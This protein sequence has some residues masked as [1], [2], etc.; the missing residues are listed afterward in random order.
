LFA[1]AVAGQEI[2]VDSIASIALS[3]LV[4]QQRALDV[5]A[6]N[7]ANANT[8]GYHASRM[9]F[10]DWLMKEPSA[11][12]PPGGSKIAYTHDRATYRDPHAGPLSH[13]G[14]PLDIAIGGD[15]FFTVQT[16]RGPR[17]TRAGHFEISTTGSIVTSQ[18]DALLDTAGRPIQVATTDGA[19][20]VTGDG[21]VSSENGQ[22][23][24]I[25][26]VLPQDMQ[27]LQA[28]GGELFNA[29]IGT[30]PVTRPKIIQGAVE[31]SNVQ[32][33]VEL[34]RMMNDLREYQFASQFVQ[35][36]ADRQQNAIDKIT[37]KNT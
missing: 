15:G 12:Q 30:T 14:N 23:G 21:T 18:G 33:T 34:A 31:Q 3:R 32:P 35:S 16:P 13:T 9:I 22:I 37:R 20:A 10:S 4:A 8:A 27:K 1:G 36:E 6:T 24:K 5:T 25:G 7:I 29:N 17:L 11:G 19:I 2:E 26:V 28:E